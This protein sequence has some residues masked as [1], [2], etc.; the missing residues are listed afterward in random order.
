[1]QASIPVAGG[2]AP[3][4]SVGCVLIAHRAQSQ[5]RPLAGRRLALE[6]CVPPWPGYFA[7]AAACHKLVQQLGVAV[8][9]YR[10]HAAKTRFV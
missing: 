9:M 2:L 5:A 1:M 8:A 3:A 4:T 7:V 10:I 6:V